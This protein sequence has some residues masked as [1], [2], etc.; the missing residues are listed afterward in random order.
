M[1][2]FKKTKS[3]HSSGCS[4]GIDELIKRIDQNDDD[5]HEKGK[6]N[7]DSYYN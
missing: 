4:S 6:S 3:L 1:H 2:V 7:I 5:D